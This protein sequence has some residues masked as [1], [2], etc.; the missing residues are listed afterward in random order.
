MGN[1]SLFLS[2]TP[3]GAPAAGDSLA[4]LAAGSSLAIPGKPL[5]K[6]KPR[7]AEW[8]LPRTS[9]GDNR[10]FLE[11]QRRK[12]PPHRGQRPLWKNA[13][14]Q[15]FAPPHTPKPH[16]RRGSGGTGFLPHLSEQSEREFP[17]AGDG[18]QRKPL[19]PKATGRMA[20]AEFL[21][22]GDSCFL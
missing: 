1:G 15:A 19:W 13:A 10:R 14:H 11:R 16:F 3:S 9:M 20:S 4:R 8:H 22:G 2:S 17:P 12:P 6:R 18:F 7:Q 5:Q 21:Y